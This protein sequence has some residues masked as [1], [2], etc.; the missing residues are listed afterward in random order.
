VEW[1][2][3]GK[4]DCEHSKAQHS[5]LTP[6]NSQPTNPSNP[7][8][9][10]CGTAF[11]NVLKDETCHPKIIAAGALGPLMSLSLDEHMAGDLELATSLAFALYNISC[12]GIDAI[13][14]CLEGG[15]IKCLVK[16]SEHDSLSIRERVAA[17][18]CSLALSKYVSKTG[19]SIVQMMISQNVLEAIMD[20][21]DSK[22]EIESMPEVTQQCVTAL[23][24]VAHDPVSHDTIVNRGCVETLINLGNMTNDTETKQVCAV[25]LSV[26]T[27]GE[28]SLNR[29]IEMK[30]LEAIIRLSSEKDTLTRQH[31]AVALCNISENGAGVLEMLEENVGMVEVLSKLS[32]TYSEEAQQDCAKCLCNL[33]SI[34]NKSVMLNKHGAVH[35]LMMIAMVRR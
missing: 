30:G 10:F 11:C 1:E 24:I 7:H 26:L 3:R 19:E 6:I 23:A 17:S 4:N 34:A 22:E 9:H 33:S 12:G 20:M 29:L 32:N 14:A 16:F 25:V 27:Y 8:Q 13:T 31:C 35:A 15:I 28:K 5:E 18:V 2:W 21:M